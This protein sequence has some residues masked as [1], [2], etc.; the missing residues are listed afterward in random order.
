MKNKKRLPT[1]LV[2]KQELERQQTINKVLRA[3]NDIEGEGRKMTISALAEYAGLSRSVFSKPHIRELLEGR[4]CRTVQGKKILDASTK[5]E[6]IAKKNKQIEDLKVRNTK[7]ER[8][9]EL[10]RGRLFLIMQNKE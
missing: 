4:E 6:I 3:I 2:E 9:C 7:L 10:L 5:S 1:G 8:E